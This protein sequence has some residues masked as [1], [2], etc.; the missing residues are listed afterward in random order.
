MQTS[1][2]IFMITF[3]VLILVSL[4]W[5]YKILLKEDHIPIGPLEDEFHPESC[6]LEEGPQKTEK[7]AGELVE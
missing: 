4:V 2:W 3:W 6:D 7:E 5:S 1:G